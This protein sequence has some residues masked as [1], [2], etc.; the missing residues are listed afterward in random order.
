MPVLS[1]ARHERFAQELAKGKT[2]DEA[3]REAGYS[4][5]RGNAARL[6]ANEGVL[7]RTRELQEAAAEKAV[8]SKAWI[9]ERLMT[10]VER[11]L[12]QEPV[13]DHDGNETGE[14]TYQGMVANKALELLGKEIGMFVDRSENNVNVQYAVSN[15]LPDEHQWE[16]ERATAH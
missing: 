14:F 8:L 4:E 10:N 11:A 16:A 6:K 1:N 13:L 2:A 9:I 7:T 5:N 12:Q 3:Y 15:D